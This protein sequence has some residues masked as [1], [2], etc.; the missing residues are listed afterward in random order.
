MLTLYIIKLAWLVWVN[1]IFLVIGVETNMLQIAMLIKLLTMW[2]LHLDNEPTISSHSRETTQKSSY[3]YE[4]FVTLQNFQ[5]NR[6]FTDL[7]WRQMHDMQCL[8]SSQ[9]AKKTTNSKN[10]LQPTKTTNSKNF[11]QM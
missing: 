11:L 2:L 1:S 7:F 8:L 9:Q 6:L 5:G 4:G 3:H 10:F